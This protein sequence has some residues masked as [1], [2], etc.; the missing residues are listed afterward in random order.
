MKIEGSVRIQQQANYGNQNS[1]RKALQQTQQVEYIQKSN[2]RL[3]G[4]KQLIEAIERSNKDL[5]LTDTS[6]KFSIHEKTKEVIVKIIDNNTKETIK[7]IPS[8]EIL[9]MVASMI[10]RNGLF[11]DEKA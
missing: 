6:L 5:K 7:E 2:T 8:E 10:E 9:D 3:P 4:E 1:E 11:L